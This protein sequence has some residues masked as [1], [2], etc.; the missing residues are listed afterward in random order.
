MENDYR[1]F[2][3]FFLYAFYLFYITALAQLGTCRLQRRLPAGAAV[4]VSTRL[5][6]GPNL[7]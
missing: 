7:A 4:D 6:S 5:F 3:Y 1:I 2:L